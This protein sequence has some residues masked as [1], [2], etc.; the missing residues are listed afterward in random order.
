MF[1]CRELYMSVSRLGD[2]NGLLGKWNPKCNFE[3]AKQIEDM[4]TNGQSGETRQKLRNAITSDVATKQPMEQNDPERVKREMCQKTSGLSDTQTE[5]GWFDSNCKTQQQRKSET[6]TSVY[7]ACM[8]G[9]TIIEMAE[10][11]KAK[12]ESY[13]IDDAKGGKRKRKTKSKR[14]RKRRITKKQRHKKRA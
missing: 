9:A 4:R 10:V 1:L 2:C 11:R 3:T 5:C 8:N 14:R 13:I 12:E 7:N 6:D